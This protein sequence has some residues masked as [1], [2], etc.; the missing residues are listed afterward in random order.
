MSL[1]KH[2]AHISLSISTLFLVSTPFSYAQQSFGGVSFS[3]VGAA[4]LGCSGATDFLADK[5]A[6]LKQSALAL[7]GTEVV[8]TK[9]GTTLQT[10]D[11]KQ[12]IQSK[13]TNKKESCKDPIAYALGTS[14][15]N[16]FIDSTINWATTGFQGTP[17]FVRNQDTFFNNIIRDQKQQFLN[18]L[19][20]SN[21]VYGNAIRYAMIAQQTGR[22]ASTSAL[23]GDNDAAVQQIN[24]FT[25]DFKQGG[26]TTFFNTTQFSSQNPVGAFFSATER[27]AQER[28]TL[29]QQK[30]DELMRSGGYLDQIKCVEWG[31]GGEDGMI[32][33][34]PLTG[35]ESRIEPNCVKK[36]VITPG[37]TIAEQVAKATQAAQERA[38]QADELNETLGR[39]L[40]RMLSNLA[41]R[42][43]AA[44]MT[45]RSR[46][47]QNTQS[48]PNV[49]SAQSGTLRDI[50]SSFDESE[51]A[52][53]NPKHLQALLKAQKD[54]LS[55]I[56]DSRIAAEESLAVLG[57]LDYC[58]PGPNENMTQL[59]NQNL[60]A[61]VSGL[62]DGFVRK[63]F[64]SSKNYRQLQPTPFIVENPVA[65]GDF[66]LN[67]PIYINE[68]V[69]D[70][71]EKGVFVDNVQNKSKLYFELF[72]ELFSREKIIAFFENTQTTQQDRDTTRGAI[73]SALL[74][75]RKLPEYSKNMKELIANYDYV[76]ET[77]TENINELESIHRQIL[78]IVRGARERHIAEQR[79]LG[80]AV[81][82]A[83]LDIQYSVSDPI[84]V[85]RVR[86]ESDTP[87]TNVQTL[88]AAE[89]AFFSPSNLYRNHNLPFGSNY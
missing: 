70:D 71:D 20:T 18:T 24:D 30:T 15:M 48:G 13:K 68:W 41:N 29:V 65:E 9:V 54:Y 10:S 88:R 66:I 67:N 84:I 27:Q 58:I 69:D 59:A 23:R 7:S 35:Q 12:Q 77:I 1:K 31:I 25:N 85:G 61:F 34:N 50:Q 73:Q 40:D 38:S 80:V 89:A 39:F 64:L 43:L 83:C 46:A 55:T 79:A 26:W 81:N 63:R 56:R 74:E 37:R 6:D 78:F 14:M 11:E 86:R 82:L 53:T 51:F 16:S 22:T 42:G 47:L 3:G 87:S 62:Q 75:T 60:G 5:I 36:E 28:E 72:R 45:P 52:I 76:D 49:S 8:G 33:R 57:K 32:V 19:P 4:V 44:L 2:I 17:Y 21:D